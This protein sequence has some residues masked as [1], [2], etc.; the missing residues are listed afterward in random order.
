MLP[1]SVLTST[2]PVLLPYLCFQQEIE[3]SFFENVFIDLRYR[4]C[5]V[6]LRFRYGTF[7]FLPV[8]MAP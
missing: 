8:R 6:L 7:H 4:Y 2:V 1:V 3:F 5:S